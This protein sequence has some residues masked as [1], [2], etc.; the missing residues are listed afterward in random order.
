MINILER[1]RTKTSATAADHQARLAEI[2]NELPAAE[3]RVRSAEA[4]RAAGL[5]D[6]S[7]AEIEKIE[8]AL[9]LAIRDRDRLRAA[10]EELER[11]AGAAEA[12][13]FLTAL[14]GRRATIDKRAAAFAFALPDTYDKLARPLVALL[15]EAAAIDAEIAAVNE[16]DRD[17]VREC[18]IEPRVS[19]PTIDERANSFRAMTFARVGFYEITSLRPGKNQLGWGAGRAAFE[20]AGL[21]P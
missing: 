4:Q 9:R 13:E 17:A 6:L 14:N 3:A 7:D 10:R 18:R 16:A 5:L 2:E 8:S 1:L 11:R 15:E 21:K 19:V 20:L 12:A